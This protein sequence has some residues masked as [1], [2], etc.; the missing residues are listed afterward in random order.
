MTVVVTDMAEEAAALVRD[1]G[2]SDHQE[3]NGGW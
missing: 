2:G 1:G 3:G